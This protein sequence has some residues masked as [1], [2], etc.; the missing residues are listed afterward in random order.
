[1]LFHISHPEVSPDDHWIEFPII[2]KVHFESV[3][4]SHYVIFAQIP[5]FYWAFPLPAESQDV[6]NTISDDMITSKML[7]NA[8]YKETMHDASR[9]SKDFEQIV[10]GVNRELQA[11]RKSLDDRLQKWRDDLK[12]KKEDVLNKGQELEAKQQ[13][14]KEEQEELS[15]KFDEIE[16][17]RETNRIRMNEIKENIERLEKEVEETYIANQKNH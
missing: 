14:C 13:K 9:L 12:K 11:R 5:P 7:V 6:P 17:K 10:A 1:M 4:R 3:Q 8:H 2:C 15:K 16:E